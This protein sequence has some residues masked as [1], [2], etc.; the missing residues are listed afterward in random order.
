MK[1]IL[2]A[3]L[4]VVFIVLFMKTCLPPTP[5]IDTDPTCTS[6]YNC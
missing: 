6:R 4:V 1:N 5:D 2:H 3:I